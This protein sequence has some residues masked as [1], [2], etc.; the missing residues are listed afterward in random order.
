ME[1]FVKLS[2]NTGGECHSA[3]SCD[4]DENSLSDLLLLC[5]GLHVSVF[6]ENESV[7]CYVERQKMTWIPVYHTCAVF[8]SSHPYNHLK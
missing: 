6:T 7:V 8:Q 5:V 1:D 3:E 4:A 2:S